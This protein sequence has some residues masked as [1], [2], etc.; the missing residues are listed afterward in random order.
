MQ[1]IAKNTKNKTEIFKVSLFRQILSYR[2]C[3]NKRTSFDDYS[4]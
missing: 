4:E 2:V 1:R 3:F